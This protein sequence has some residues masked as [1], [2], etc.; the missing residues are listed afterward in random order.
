MPGTVGMASVGGTAG[1][2]ASSRATASPRGGKGRRGRRAEGGSP[3]RGGRQSVAPFGR[4]A[5]RWGI[6]GDRPACR[7]GPA[8]AW[9]RAGQAGC[10]HLRPTAPRDAAPTSRPAESRPCSRPAVPSRRRPTTRPRCT[11]RGA[12]RAG[13][14]RTAVGPDEPFCPRAAGPGRPVGRGPTTPSATPRR[15]ARRVVALAHAPGRT[16]RPGRAPCCDGCVARP[17]RPLVGAADVVSC[18][19]AG[20]GRPAR[21]GRAAVRRACGGVGPADPAA[22]GRR[23]R[24]C[25]RWPSVGCPLRPSPDQV[26]GT[27]FGTVCS[28]AE[29]RGGQHPSHRRP[30]ARPGRAARWSTPMSGRAGAPRVA[31]DGTASSAPATAAGPIPATALGG[32]TTAGLRPSRVGR[33]SARSAPASGRSRLSSTLGGGA[34]VVGVCGLARSRLRLGAHRVLCRRPE[35]DD[36]AERALRR[37]VAAGSGSSP[38]GAARGRGWERIG[39]GGERHRRSTDLRRSGS[40]AARAAAGSTSLR[41]DPTPWSPDRY[42]HQLHAEAAGPA[43][44]GA[45]DASAPTPVGPWPAALAQ[46]RPTPE[47]PAEPAPCRDA[48][49]AA[50][51]PP[52]QRAVRGSRSR[53][54]PDRAVRRAPSGRRRRPAGGSPARASRRRIPAPALHGGP[55]DGSEPPGAASPRGASAA[56]RG[57]GGVAGPV[58]GAGLRGLRPAVPGVP[59][60]GAAPRNRHPP[61]DLRLEPGRA[62]LDGLCRTRVVG[63]PGCHRRR[64]AVGVGAHGPL[65]LGGC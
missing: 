24:R 51:A 22:R 38:A 20:P 27:G 32:S 55:P 31:A 56:A 9:H 21:P 17:A 40:A 44:R 8:S 35:R 53:P 11:R 29:R 37:V 59:T 1:G 2:A 52:G 13:L 7:R 45:C 15:G 25:P 10:G 30:R 65:A 54:T 26:D 3:G 43:A 12:R 57:V 61:L 14:R 46:P 18:G 28:A 63:R 48:S 49:V 4:S 64:N 60:A 34:Q 23:C 6:V 36:G 58:I 42:L 41:R 5:G 33:I 62:R 39:R 50:G 16:P 19:T 47:R